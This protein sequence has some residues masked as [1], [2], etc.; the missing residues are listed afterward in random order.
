MTDEK[1]MQK[2][3][4]KQEEKWNRDPLSSIVFA[5][6]LIWAGSL[7]LASNMGY[8]DVFTPI[9]DN[10]PIEA[11]IINEIDIDLP[12]FNDLNFLDLIRVFFLG[13]AVIMLFEIALRLLLPAYRRRVLGTF[14]GFAIFLGVG[15]ANF[16][17]FWPMVLIAIGVSVL[18]GGFFSRR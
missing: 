6:L 3:E 1:E 18:L 17:L 2:Q 11:N 10:L 15:F 7:F 16:T 8:A 9:L 14:V 13:G 12:F 5:L 4:E